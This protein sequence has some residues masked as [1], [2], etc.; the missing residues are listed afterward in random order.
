[1]SILKELHGL[2]ADGDTTAKRIADLVHLNDRLKKKRTFTDVEVAQIV[3]QLRKDDKDGITK[4]LSDEA[5][6]NVI[7]LHHVPTLEDADIT[8][9]GEDADAEA[10][11]TDDPKV[12]SKAGDYKVILLPNE[13]VVLRRGG[14]KL[15]TDIAQMPLV[16]WK[17]LC[18]Q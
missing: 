17:Q 12:I 7:K 6:R 16:I 3:Q 13:Q 11:G 9:Q 4:A 1:M 14:D 10:E 15:Y 2:V 8:E 5:L 18:R